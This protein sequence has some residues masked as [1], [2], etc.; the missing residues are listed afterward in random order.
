MNL[1]SF[2]FKIQNEFHLILLKKT[3]IDIISDFEH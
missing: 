1:N 2:Q 3:L